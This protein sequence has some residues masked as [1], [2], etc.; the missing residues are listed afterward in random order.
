MTR[1]AELILEGNTPE[2][3]RNQIDKEVKNEIDLLDEPVAF[4][5]TIYNED[6]TVNHHVIVHRAK[7][8]FRAIARSIDRKSSVEVFSIHNIS[9]A[10]QRLFEAT[11]SGALTNPF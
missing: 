9:Q 1:Y 11:S 2:E 8:G 5:G 4:R 6:F 10:L 3:A 7:N